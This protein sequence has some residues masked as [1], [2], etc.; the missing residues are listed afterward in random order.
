MVSR[1]KICRGSGSVQI[2]PMPAGP[3]SLHFQCRLHQSHKEPT[4]SHL[5]GLA[6][7]PVARLHRLMQEL[8]EE[9]WLRKS[10]CYRCSQT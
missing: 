10:S 4:K 6:S 7:N 5:R 1:V 9:A 2:S 8:S 3:G